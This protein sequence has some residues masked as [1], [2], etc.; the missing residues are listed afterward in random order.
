M[1]PQGHD[2]EA[3]ATPCHP[4]PGRR[5]GEGPCEAIAAEWM[6]AG[7]V[8]SAGGA[9][10]LFVAAA[11]SSAARPPTRLRHRQVL[12]Y[13]YSVSPTTVN[14]LIFLSGNRNS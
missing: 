6:L 10:V 7:V 11:L 1:H 13:D 12:N 3:T 4:E 2:P 9:G 5:P 8:E 14:L